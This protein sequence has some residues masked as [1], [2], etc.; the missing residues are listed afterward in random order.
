MI[1]SQGTGDR[2]RVSAPAVAVCVRGALEV[3]KD[4]ASAK[5]LDKESL[6]R[7]PSA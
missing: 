5:K 3:E 7:E 1:S 2:K 4:Y 6:K